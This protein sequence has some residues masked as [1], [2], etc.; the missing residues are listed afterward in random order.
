MYIDDLILI[1]FVTSSQA[2]IGAFKCSSQLN[3]SPSRQK[4]K[5]KKSFFLFFIFLKFFNFFFK[6]RLT[7]NRPVLTGG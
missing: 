4:K 1:L 7:E 3:E 6:N 2:Q 5:K